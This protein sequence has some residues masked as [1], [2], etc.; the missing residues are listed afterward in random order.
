MEIKDIKKAHVYAVGRWMIF[1]MIVIMFLQ[2]IVYVVSQ[3]P[4]TTYEMF[5]LFEAKPLMGL[6]SLDLLYLVNNTLLIMIYFSISL[7]LLA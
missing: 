3:P 1:A 7:F 6:L 2:V 4:V 5:E